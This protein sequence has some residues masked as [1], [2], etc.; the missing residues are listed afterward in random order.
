MG[1]SKMVGVRMSPEIRT[2]LDGHCA[3]AGIPL[4]EL[5][6]NPALREIGRADVIEGMPAAGR[7]RPEETLASEKTARK[8]K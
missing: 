4:S 6:R 3:K 5:L 7:P 8:R 1:E 2:A